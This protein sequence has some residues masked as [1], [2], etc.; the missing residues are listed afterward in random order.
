[1]NRWTAHIV[2]PIESAVSTRTE[3]SMS[4]ATSA[5]GCECSASPPTYPYSGRNPAHFSVVAEFATVLAEDQ[6]RAAL[7]VTAPAAVE[8]T[9]HRRTGARWR[10]LAGEEVCRPFHVSTRPSIRAILANGDCASAVLLTFDQAVADANW[11]ITL[12]DDLVAALNG[13]AS[14]ADVATDPRLMQPRSIRPLD[15]AIGNLHTVALDAAQTA[16]LVNRSRAEGTTV[17]AAIVAA[18]S[19]LPTPQRGRAN[20]GVV[21][22]VKFRSLT[23]AGGADYITCSCSATVPYGAPWFWDQARE[24]S[25]QLA[26]ARSATITEPSVT[27]G[28]RYRALVSN[29]GVQELTDSGPIRPTALWGP[30]LRARIDRECA[31]GVITYQGRLRMV[32]SGNGLAGD[33]LDG[34]RNTLVEECE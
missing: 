24:V 14:S 7:D 5:D 27:S 18:A 16:E 1:M 23:P 4:L 9:V 3:V 2:F 34:L 22:P 8:L 28:R 30:V 11:A 29:L 13:D 15:A 20:V 6:L 32:A 10:V 17:H 19:R 25:A 31:I 21:I 12:I 33:F 26:G